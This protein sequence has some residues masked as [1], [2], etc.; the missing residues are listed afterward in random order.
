[1]ELARGPRAGTGVID[2]LLSAL[3][4][5]I[6]AAHPLRSVAGDAEAVA[7]TPRCP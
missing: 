6:A 5:V 4:P 2:P 7:S 3:H 1:M